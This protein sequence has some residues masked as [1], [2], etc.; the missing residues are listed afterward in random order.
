VL[1]V[2]EI[3]AVGDQSFQAK[4]IERIRRLRKSGKTL[5]FVSHNAG[6]V[7]E[8]CDRALWLDHGSLIMQGPAKEI[9]AAYQATNV[10]TAPA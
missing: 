4:C 2:D 9:V 8:L 1:I 6:M 10:A 3:L 7:L 5:L